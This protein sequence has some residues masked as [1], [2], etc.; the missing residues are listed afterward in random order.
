MPNNVTPETD[1]TSIENLK[2]DDSFNFKSTTDIQLNVKVSNP[3]FASEKF[4]INIYDDFPTVG[5]LIMSGFTDAS[6]N[7]KLEFRVPAPLTEIYVEKINSY[8]ASEVKKIAT[9]A[10]VSADFKKTTPVVSLREQANSGLDCNTGLTKVYE[11]YSGSLNINPGEVIGLKGTYSGN[12]NMNG[13]VLRVC[14]SA[15]NLGI[16]LNNNS[17]EVYFLEGSNVSI[18]SL[19]MNASGA[20]IYNYSTNLSFTSGVAFACNFENNGKMTVNND[21]DINSNGSFT[22]TN[23]GEIA[24]GNNMNNGRNMVNNN[25]ILV[26]GTYQANSNST[27]VN[28]CKL[29]INQNFIV[30]NGGPFTNNAYVG[31]GGETKINSGVKLTNVNGAQLNTK[32]I[33][34]DGT[35]EGTGASK[36]T[37]VVTGTF[38]YIN[39][40]TP[41]S[42]NLNVCAAN[43]T[44]SK[45]E[46]N[47]FFNCNNYIPTSACN[48]QGV[49]QP[50][51]K[52]TDKDGVPDDQD[53]YPTDPTR[54][55]NSYYPTAST[56]ATYG[57][58]DLW[59]ARGDYDFNDLIVYFRITKVLNASNKVV[60]IKNTYIVKAIGASYDNGFGFQLDDVT[61]AEIAKVTGSSLTKGGI[62]LNANKTE[63]GQSKAVIIAYD[64]PEPLIKRVG[65]SMFN[66]I[67]ANGA[68]TSTTNEI[69]I[70]FTSPLDQSKVAQSKINPFIFTN[71]KREVEVHLPN[72]APTDKA[73]KALLGTLNDTSKPGSGRYYKTANNLPWVI[74]I[75]VQFKYPAEKESIMDAYSN[76]GKW[77]GSNGTQY[78]DWFQNKPGYTEPEKIY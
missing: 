34:I 17:C 3:A 21:L 43:Y 54:A 6:Q 69:V 8:G 64:T 40:G 49:G 23:N 52:D 29:V 32:N 37:V 5:N 66:T 74:E 55:F 14:G 58:E 11:N 72:F 27:N 38:N 30:N 67:K 60:D 68:G 46:W 15:T 62:S 65:G 4:R 26:K 18:S 50:T 76:F 47:A 19:N 61:S 53:D 78:V 44:N 45:P 51:T 9:S 71:G 7:L 77:A 24:V 36:S 56:W 31:V 16:N 39:S 20:R 73:D 22:F 12:I 41:F 10:Y 35:I 13:G 1:P 59:P 57:F 75:P 28:N 42:G 48:P 2:V 33:G 63:A 70:N 25:Y